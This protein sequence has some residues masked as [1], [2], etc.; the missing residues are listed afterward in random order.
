MRIVVYHPFYPSGQRALRSL[1]TNPF[2]VPSAE[3]G[4]LL[5]PHNYPE[6]VLGHIESSQIAT[7]IRI[8]HDLLFLFPKSR[9]RNVCDYETSILKAKLGYEKATIMPRKGKQNEQAADNIKPNIR[10]GVARWINVPLTDDTLAALEASEYTLE[11]VGAR[12]LSMA[13]TGWDITIKRDDKSNGFSCFGFCDD[14]NNNTDRVG[15]SGWGSNAPDAAL[16]FVFKYF[17]ELGGVIP[18]GVPTTQR[19]FR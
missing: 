19:R 1:T 14:P 9:G 17:D 2:C 16:V 6:D 7:H 18:V 10:S 12:L 8:G 15:L 4:F 5:F 11:D 3:R 13:S